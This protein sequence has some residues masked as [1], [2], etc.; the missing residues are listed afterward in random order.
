MLHHPAPVIFEE[1]GLRYYGPIDGHDLPVLIRTF[2][3]L[4][5]ET[6]PCILHVIT[7]KGRGFE[8]ALG[9]PMKF[10]GLGPFKTETGDT[11][12]TQL[13]TYSQIFARALTDFAKE[14]K[15]ITAITGAMRSQSSSVILPAEDAKLKPLLARRKKAGMRMNLNQLGEAIL[16]ENEAEHR[17]QA[18]ITRL[19]SPD[20]DYL[21]VKISAIFSQIHLVGEAETLAR[22]TDRLRQLYRVAMQN[23]VNGRPKF[24]N[25]DMEE[26]KEFALTVD[27]FAALLADPTLDAQQLT[28][29]PCLRKAGDWCEWRVTRCVL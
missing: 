26:Y 19:E 22:I 8:P 1:F 11:P 9:N 2:E 28:D 7:E 12:P 27:V 16:G 21:S 15:R 4:K 13:P 17:I 5:N 6:E 10:H 25:L 18:V 29:T 20:C 24:V 14:D 3:H 23:P